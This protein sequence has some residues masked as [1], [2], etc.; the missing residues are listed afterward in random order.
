MT[1]SNTP[2]WEQATPHRPGT[3]DLLNGT[4]TN[5]TAS[6]DPK[7]PAAEEFN[8]LAAQVVALAGMIPLLR[9]SVSFSAGAP[10]IVGL[11]TVRTDIVA[12]TNVLTDVTIA[13]TPAGGGAGD[14]TI[15]WPAS[16][17]PASETRPIVSLNGINLT[18]RA[19]SAVLVTN[20]VRVRT[21]ASDA[22]ITDMD[23][24]VEVN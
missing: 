1:V 12:G 8:Q 9:I 24:T 18:S 15:S 14:I 7:N 17:F 2:T 20:G 19:P 13:R 21:T 3:S 10:V 11:K 16:K 4:K 23:F 22:T 5:K 6:V